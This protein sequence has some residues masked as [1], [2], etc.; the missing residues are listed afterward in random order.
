MAHGAMDG[1]RGSEANKPGRSFFRC[2]FRCLQPS[3][4]AV[5][6]RENSQDLRYAHT[7]GEDTYERYVLP[8]TCPPLTATR[9]SLAGLSD[10]GRGYSMVRVRPQFEHML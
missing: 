4:I 1:R 5:D 9:I 8:E 3:S 10:A 7:L 6:M 2:L